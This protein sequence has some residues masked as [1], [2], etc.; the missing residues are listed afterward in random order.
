MSVDSEFKVWVPVPEDADGV[1]AVHVQGWREAYGEL[2]PE[3]F[4][5]DAVLAARRQLW[6]RILGGS[7]AV[8][9]QN[10]V[11][12][13][14]TG[15]VIGIATVSPTRDVEPARAESLAALYITAD[16]YGRGVGEALLTEVL[17]DRPAQL[18]VA[19]ENPRARAFYRKH[20]FVEDGTETTDADLEGFAE[21]RMVR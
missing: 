6:T 9:A 18:W 15:K 11:A 16:W 10:R 21:V 19:R 14:A 4:Y 20:G 3:K 2:L 17:G 1:A 5:D 12:M 13:D 8:L 7:D